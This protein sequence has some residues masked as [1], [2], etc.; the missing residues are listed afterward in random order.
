MCDHTSGN[1]RIA[2]NESSTRPANADTV[3]GILNGKRCA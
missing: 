2:I 3:T 1:F